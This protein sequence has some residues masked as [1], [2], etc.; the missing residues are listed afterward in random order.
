[1]K[2]TN[3]LII[4]LLIIPLFSISLFTSRNFTDFLV[5]PKQFYFIFFATGL[6]AIYFLILIFNYKP[7]KLSLNIIDI[8]I[9]AYTIY[10]L[11]R[12]FIFNGTRLIGQE[13]IIFVLF[14][15]L[16][17][18]IKYCVND[19]KNGTLNIKIII[20][21]IL[22]FGLLQVFYGLIQL[23]G[24]IPNVLQDF[25][26]GGSFGNPSPYTNYLVSILPIALGFALFNQENSIFDKIIKILSISVFVGI[27][28]ILP[29]TLT[30]TSWLAAFLGIL[31]IL[32]YKFHLAAK[33]NTLLNS[34]IK[35]AVVGIILVLVSVFVIIKLYNYKKDSAQGRLFI[36]QTT[37]EI[38]KE[39]PVFGSGFNTFSIEHN[40]QQA[41]Y[42]QEN[43][44]DIKR[45]YLADNVLFAFNE[46]LEITSET[47]IIGI[48]LFLSLIGF[49]LFINN[50][51]KKSVN[52]EN[53]FSLIFQTSLII[54]LF[55]A[56]FSYP[57]HNIPIYLNFII[58]LAIISSYNKRNV[59]GLNITKL[60]VKL[61]ALV[62]L[63]LCVYLFKLEHSRFT[64]NKKWT[65]AA[66]YIKTGEQGKAIK[67]YKN[68]YP[69]L[70]YN[71][72]FLYNYG[73]E[74]SIIGQYEKSLEILIEAENKINDA[75]YYTYLGNTYEGLNMLN[76]A[77][78]A[79]LNASYI[80]PHKFYPKYRLVYIY[81][82][83]NRINEALKLADEIVKMDMKVDSEVM[84]TIKA[85]M[86]KFIEE[87]TSFINKIN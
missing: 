76:E 14:T 48:L 41:K 42:F 8:I 71:G 75:D 86:V 68:I 77:E 1:M 49:T 61:F 55:T 2:L 9:L 10:V 20:F 56:L 31:I 57:F 5:L 81:A 59:I 66:R 74:L 46:Y 73:A 40:K 39:N 83:T 82:K 58:C 3:K 11:S 60:P 34:Y 84:E 80:I 45:S 22:L 78:E 62:F 50:T 35:K 64:A 36:W 21:S 52:G 72:N 18:V 69:L 13:I 38:I 29:P 33:V 7:L 27:L 15:A 44:N 32:N 16:Y 67:I 65:R 12:N 79:F 54:I 6:L 19:I 51:K 28:I 47:G 23:Y 70:S 30:R 37:I 53:Y 85:E 4:T 63:V 87:N 43:P 17:F 24:F 26:I 25:K